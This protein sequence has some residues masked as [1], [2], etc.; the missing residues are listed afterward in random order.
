M[1]ANVVAAIRCMLGIVPHIVAAIT[2]LVALLHTTALAF[3]ILKHLGVA[4]PLY[5]AWGTLR[6]KGTLTV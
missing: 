1:A 3:Q 2:G 4:Y 5:M 6:E